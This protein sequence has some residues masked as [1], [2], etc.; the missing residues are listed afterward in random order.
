MWTVL[1]IIVCVAAACV[2][3]AIA[4]H[5]EEQIVE[6]AETNWFYHA[7]AKMVCHNYKGY[8]PNEDEV[9][10]S[11]EFVREKSEY[12]VHPVGS[13]LK[14]RS[15]CDNMLK[16]AGNF[17]NYNL[18]FNLGEV[19]TGIAVMLVFVAVVTLGVIYC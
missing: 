18:S 13:Y 19:G 2:A 14:M 16:W 1:F 15:E 12:D 10:A 17:H 6:K 3:A 4:M 7:L 11:K 8:Y 9:K 5:N